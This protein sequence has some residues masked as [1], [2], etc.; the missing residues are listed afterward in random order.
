MEAAYGLQIDLLDRYTARVAIERSALAVTDRRKLHALATQ[1][2][3][4]LG[5]PMPPPL[6]D[7]A[8]DGIEAPPRLVVDDGA[9]RA[10]IDASAGG[11]GVFLSD[12]RRMANFARAGCG[13]PVTAA[14]L[15]A[16][17]LGHPLVG[18]DRKSGRV[19]LRR[20][21]V[22]VVGVLTIAE[23][24]GLQTAK[25]E[26][27]LGTV[28]VRARPHAG[29]GDGTAL[30]ALARRIHELGAANDTKLRL[31][32][33]AMTALVAAADRWKIGVDPR[34]NP[35]A[36]YIDQLTDMALR[37]AVAS[38]L[39]TS[40]LD[41]KL[42]AEIPVTAMRTAIGII[43]DLVLPASRHVLAPVSAAS[44]EEADAIRI[45]AALR[46]HT[47]AADPIIE[48]RELYRGLQNSVPSMPRF[49]AAARLL[50]H[51]KLITPAPPPDG[52]KGEYLASEAPLHN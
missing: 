25:A 8:Q 4:A 16:T 27:S 49:K 28:F 30:L 19:A 7:D 26:E 44:T 11:T 18:T 43:D 40:A 42:S 32:E 3:L 2:A 51:L 35:L 17:A 45:I 23:C 46:R 1:A 47:S 15:N 10:L 21:P 5:N 48:R 6:A 24:E 52:R 50:H 38:H 34:L 20:L 9:L 12:E 36:T 33:P 22:S 39:V 29:G 13:D 31:H 37:L 41:M 14:A